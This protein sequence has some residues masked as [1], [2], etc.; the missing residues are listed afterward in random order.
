M[1]WTKVLRVE[2]YGVDRAKLFLEYKG[3]FAGSLKPEFLKDNMVRP[4]P[5]ARAA[6]K[7]AKAAELAKAAEPVPAEKEGEYERIAARQCLQYEQQVRDE[8]R[9]SRKEHKEQEKGETGESTAKKG[10]APVKP[11]A[12]AAAAAK[13]NTAT[14]TCTESSIVGAVLAAATDSSDKFSATELE[15]LTREVRDEVDGK[16][17]WCRVASLWHRPTDGK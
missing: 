1:M 3:Q 17:K 7:A 9:L 10:T 5:A 11:G 8:V 13:K 15:W 2:C 6:S 12:N 16:K 4:A 14:G